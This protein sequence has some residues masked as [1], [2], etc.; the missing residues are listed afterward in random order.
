MR[1]VIVDDDK[2][3]CS[4]LKVI[5][6]ANKEIIVAA[7]GN[8]G[9][10]AVA[11]FENHQPDVLLMDI[12]MEV[13]SGLDSAELIL[14]KFPQAKI[15]FLTTFSDDEYIIRALK[16]GARGYMLKQNF[17]SIV[18]ALRAVMIGHRVFGDEVVERIPVMLQEHRKPD[19]SRYGI[20]D[21]EAGL[22]ALVA[23]GLNNKEIAEELYLS[24]GTIRNYLSIILEKLHLRDR[25]QLAVFFYKNH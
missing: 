20:H 18:P 13:M 4:S 17:E 14:V 19:F 12:R 11:L 3:V 5:L 23:Q 22:I 1:V 2:L 15:L 9:R 24:E 10:Q 7:V 16:M 21:K 25:T 8:D 6:E